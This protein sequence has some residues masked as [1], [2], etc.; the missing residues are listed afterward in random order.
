M[1]SRLLQSLPKISLGISIVVVICM[2]ISFAALFYLYGRT[3]SKGIDYGV[4]DV[5]LKKQLADR[6][7]KRKETTAYTQMLTDERKKERVIRIVTDIIL[8]LL[9]VFVGGLTIFSF[10]LRGKGEQVYFGDTAYLTVLTSSMQTKNEDNPYLKE[11]DDGVR[12]HQYALIGVDKADPA[13][14]KEGD[15]IAFRYEGDTIYVHRIVTVRESNGER[16]FTTMGDANSVSSARETD[17]TADRIVG[18]FNGYHKGYLGVLLIYMRSD[19]GIVALVFAFLLLAVIDSAEI[20]ITRS[21]EKRQTALATQMDSVEAASLEQPEEE[22]PVPPAKSATESVD[23][24]AE[25]A[26]AI[27]YDPDGFYEHI[28][29]SYAYD[30]TEEEVTTLPAAGKDGKKGEEDGGKRSGDGN[31]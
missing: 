3:K 29:D 15:I 20:I 18:V 31:A 14:L 4:E 17:I 6:L 10:V 16:L 24:Q 27:N 19:I 11:N 1:T 21:Y 12:I 9:L 28:S 23:E 8:A 30:V 7:K 22:T 5:A 25:P 26:V 2:A 13:N